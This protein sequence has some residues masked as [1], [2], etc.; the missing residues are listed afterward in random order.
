MWIIYW[1]IADSAFNVPLIDAMRFVLLLKKTWL[2]TQT[3]GKF[4]HVPF[5][6][7][8]EYFSHFNTF[9]PTS[10]HQL[11]F[12]NSYCSK[13]YFQHFSSIFNSFFLKVSFV[14]DLVIHVSIYSINTK[15][16]KFQ[17]KKSLLLSIVIC[18][19][20]DW[21]NIYEARTALLNVLCRLYLKKKPRL[22]LRILR[23]I[24][25]CKYK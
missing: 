14:Y 24:A 1:I 17:S 6:F 25:A 8:Y 22:K 18:M 15:F 10:F 23:N 12:T 2:W 20:H 7:L 21:C 16:L 11:V 13:F 3:L 19:M 4:T 5:F 9:S